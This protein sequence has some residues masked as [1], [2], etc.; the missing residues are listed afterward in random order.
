MSMQQAFAHWKA[1]F[2][3]SKNSH[4]QTHNASYGDFLDWRTFTT[5]LYH[6]VLLSFNHCTLSSD[7]SDPPSW[8][9]DTISAFDNVKQALADAILLVHPVL[10]ATTSVMTDTSNVAVGAVLQQYLNGQWCLLCFFSR[11][12]TTAETRY[13]MHDRKLLAIYLFIRHS[14]YFLEGREFHELT[15][16]K[17]LT[18]TLSSRPERHSPRQVRHLDFIS[19]FT[20]N[21]CHVQGAANTASDALSRLEAKWKSPNRD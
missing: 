11:G 17:P 2:R 9:D 19:Q 14:R 16:H 8:A 5:G 18:Y 1:K 7:A 4:G 20:T 6:M 15:D 21:L 10:N 12:L 13:S 3:V